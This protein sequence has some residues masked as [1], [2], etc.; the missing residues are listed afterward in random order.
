MQNTRMP[1]QTGAEMHCWEEQP[2]GA[3]QVAWKG[4]LAPES[5][6]A[7][8]RGLLRGGPQGGPGSGPWSRVTTAVAGT[9]LCQLRDLFLWPLVS[10][11]GS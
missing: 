5:T 11:Q 9:W 8:G 4:Q 3:Q 6:R 7:L 10:P 2:L 1:D